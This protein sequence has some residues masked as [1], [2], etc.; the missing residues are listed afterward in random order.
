M[1]KFRKKVKVAKDVGW[2]IPGLN[3]KRWLF[4]IFL[5]S[6]LM[7]LGFLIICDIRPI[8]QIME[9]IR[10]AALVLPTE[11]MAVAIIFIGAI[12]FFSGWKKTTLSIM[13]LAPSEGRNLLEKLYRRNKLNKGAKIVAIGGGTGLSMLLRGIK[14]YTNNITAVVTVGD[15][16]G[17]SGRLRSDMGILPP[18]DS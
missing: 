9:F 15:D 10:K 17:S 11:V 8:Y 5:G 2:L 4:L 18:G 12:V 7:V 1:N 6:V 13:D 14:K 16:G 3:V